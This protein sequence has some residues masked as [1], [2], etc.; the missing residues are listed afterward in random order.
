LKE[1][2]EDIE[3]VTAEDILE[4]SRDIF[5]KESASLTLLGPVGDERLY[6]WGLPL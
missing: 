4:L 2:E 5:Q 6:E 1:V 3:K